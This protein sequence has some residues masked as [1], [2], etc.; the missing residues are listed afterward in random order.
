MTC[1]TKFFFIF[2]ILRFIY[3]GESVHRTQFD[4]KRKTWY[5]KLEKTFIS[6]HILH[7]HWYTCPISLPVHWNP[8]HRSLL[9]VVSATSAPLFN[10]F[11]VNETFAIKAAISRLYCEPLYVTNTSHRKQETFLEECRL[12]WVF[13]RKENAQLLFDSIHLKH[14]RHFDY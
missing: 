10:L 2:I 13:V 11:V 7:Q 1:W 5:S 6:P 3:E 4:I 12:H 9:T 8:Q 14:G